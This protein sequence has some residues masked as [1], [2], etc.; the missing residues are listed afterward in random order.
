LALAN[1][2]SHKGWKL[3]IVDLNITQ[4]EE[5]VAKLGTENTMFIEADVSKWEDNVKFFEATKERFGRID[6]G[7]SVHQHEI[8][9]SRGKRGNCRYARPTCSV[10]KTIKAESKDD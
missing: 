5:I 4:G 10:G 8:T 6:F 3:A 2:L 1:D 7:I 9:H